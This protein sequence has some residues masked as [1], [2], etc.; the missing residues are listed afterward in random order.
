MVLGNI[1]VMK[2]YLSNKFQKKKH[3]L[4]LEEMRKIYKENTKVVEYPEHK[5]I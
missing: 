5:T 1:R 2:V 3:Y 4:K